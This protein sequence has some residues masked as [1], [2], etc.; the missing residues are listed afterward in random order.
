VGRLF[1]QAPHEVTKNHKKGSSS[2]HVDL[3]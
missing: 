2:L 1:D 3:A